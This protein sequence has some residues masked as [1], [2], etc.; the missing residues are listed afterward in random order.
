MPCLALQRCSVNI[1]GRNKWGSFF[2]PRREE[3]RLFL[4]LQCPWHPLAR[5]RR[6][7]REARE[8]TSL[9][10]VPFPQCRQEQACLG[11]IPAFQ[12][13]WQVP[14]IQMHLAG[15]SEKKPDI[16]PSVPRGHDS[17]APTRLGGI[18]D[19]ICLTHLMTKTCRLE[20]VGRNV[21]LC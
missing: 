9:N 14:S 16:S 17:G 13:H 5:V 4:R 10:A 3:A 15:A 21:Q 11:S 12:G 20:C 1:C 19:I 7:R 2:T 8:D 18:S 6:A